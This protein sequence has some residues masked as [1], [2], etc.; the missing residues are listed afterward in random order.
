MKNVRYSYLPQQFA[1]PSEIMDKIKSVVSRGDFTLG[2]EVAEFEQHFAKLLG[3]K[4]AIGVNSGTDA[5][6]ISLKAAGIGYGDEVITVSN[7][8]ASTAGAIN[9]VGAKPVIVDCDDSFCINPDLIEPKITSKTKAILPVQLTGNVADMDPIV[10]IAEKYGLMIIEDACQA[11][12]AEYK[13]R[14]AGTWGI[15]AGFS[16]HPLKNL[17]VWGDGGVAVTNDDEI[18]KRIRI[19]RNNGILDRDL[20]E[21][22]G[23]NTRLDTIQAVVGN[24]LIG[25]TEEITNRRI[26]NA[27]YYDEQLS[28][29]PGVRI[30]PRRAETKCVY[31]VY[32]TFVED[33][34]ACLQFCLDRGLEVKVHYP[35]PLHRQKALIPFISD[36]D[37]FEVADR[38]ARE[39]MTLPVD[40]HLSRE[41]QD[42]VLDTLREFFSGR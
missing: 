7:T 16:L 28:K 31:H 37:E 15:A 39:M 34:D 24:W 10:N 21:E 8:F 17:N 18:A 40:Q 19:L 2:S 30:P 14:K 29:I 1:D 9:E 23:Y 11:I 35:I 22:L 4:H 42:I 5:I 33:R 41:E 3:V 20:V 13:G 32:Q 25:Q 27:Q 12:L 36:P 38:H 26:K 6:K